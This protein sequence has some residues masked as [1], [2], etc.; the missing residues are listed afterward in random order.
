M[1]TVSEV[2]TYL[3]ENRAAGLPAASLAEVFDRLTWCLSDNGG[4]MLRVRKDWLECDDPVKIEVALGMSETFPYETR[5]EM[6]AKFDRIADRWPRL[7][8][9][10]DKIIRMW[11]QQF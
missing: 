7:T 1:I 3:V 5:E 10:C 6:V 2:M 11:D 4:E 8:G 9:R